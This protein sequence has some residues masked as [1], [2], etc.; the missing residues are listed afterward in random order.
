LAPAHDV[1]GLEYEPMT[2]VTMADAL[3]ARRIEELSLPTYPVTPSDAHVAVHEDAAGKPKVVF[4]MNPSTTVLAAKFALPGVSELAEVWPNA[5]AP[6]L[7]KKEGSFEVELR[8]RRVRIFEV[9]G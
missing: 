8:K 7:K 2:D 9:R 5:N 6:V 1:T 4:V 3:V